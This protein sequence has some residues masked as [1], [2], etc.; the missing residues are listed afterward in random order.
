MTSHSLAYQT[1][2][3]VI[4]PLMA[5]APVQEDDRMI[6]VETRFGTIEFDRAQAL[7]FPKCV[8]GFAG[9]QEF[10]L[11]RI[12]GSEESH[13]M[14]LQSLE[15]QD[16]AFIVMFYDPASGLYEAR[17]LDEARLHLGIDEADGAV[18]L[19]AS[20]QQT[21]DQVSMFVNMRAP[22]FIDTANRLAWQFILPNDHYE[23]RHEIG[24]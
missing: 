23:V 13:L 17:D 4:A 1:L 10:G 6:A 3:R 20:L 8:P 22:L 14:L 2:E 18:M 19:I 11:A 12:P 9:Y 24:D 7:T 5:A 16:L 21:G 15:P